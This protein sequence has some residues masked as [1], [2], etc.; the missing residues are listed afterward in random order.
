MIPVGLAYGGDVSKAMSLMLEAANKHSRVLQEPRPS[1]IFDEFA[2]NA[3]S[4]KLRCFV[5]SMDY[6]IETV[7]ELHE[8]INQKFNDAR[9]V[10]AFPQRD[11]HLD[12][13]R[14]LD[15]RVLREMPEP[16]V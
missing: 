13:S 8:A 10:I 14:P 16:G 11:V 2:D 3:L 5:A 4:L 7:S 15:I 1:V 9:L 12:A 6:R